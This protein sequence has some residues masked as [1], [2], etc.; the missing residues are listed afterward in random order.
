MFI[1]VSILVIGITVSPLVFKQLDMWHA[2]GFWAQTLIMLIFSQSFFEKRN[3]LIGQNNSLRLLSIWVGGLTAFVCYRSLTGFGTYNTESFFPYFNFLCL[4]ILYHCV[5]GYLTQSQIEKIVEWMRWAV[6]GTCFICVL[7]SFGLA[8]FFKL[9]EQT[10]VYDIFKNSPV[11]GFLGNGTHLSGFLASTTPL[12]FFSMNR[13]NALSLIMIFLVLI[14]TGTKMFDPAI[15]GLAIF[16]IF[17]FIYLF[18]VQRKTALYVLVVFGLI[19]AWVCSYYGNLFSPSG[20]VE[21]WQFYLDKVAKNGFLTGFG[22]GKV[23][24]VHLLT[25]FP[26]ARHLHNEYLHFLFELGFIG[27]VLIINV[28][29]DFLREKIYNNTQFILKM[30]VLGFLGSCFFNYP[31]HLWMPSVWAMFAYAS[32][33]A[34]KNEEMAYYD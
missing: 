28:V 15:S 26:K 29:W 5:V 12:F 24:E 27:V 30:M 9:Y 21:L 32:Y 7:Q 33:H 3:P 14:L 17:L 23:N 13:R 8:Q 20:R 25:P 10:E 19:V 2:A 1:L 34:I 18:R 11:V 16:T 22:L 4:L 31:A 6:I